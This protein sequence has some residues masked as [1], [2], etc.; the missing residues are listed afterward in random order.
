ML[1]Q[2]NISRGLNHFGL[3]GTEMKT[4]CCRRCSGGA[5]VYIRDDNVCSNNCANTVTYNTILVNNSHNVLDN[6]KL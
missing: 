3:N 6:Y 4:K 5:I 1:V 2:I